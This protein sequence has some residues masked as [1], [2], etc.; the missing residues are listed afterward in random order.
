LNSLVVFDKIGY[1]ERVKDHVNGYYYFMVNVNKR[2][3]LSII[4]LTRVPLSGDLKR[5]SSSHKP[6]WNDSK[7]FLS[8]SL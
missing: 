1:T 6:R 8:R 5:C 7:R 3:S 4:L 2:I